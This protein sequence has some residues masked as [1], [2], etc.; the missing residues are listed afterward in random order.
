MDASEALGI[1]SADGP[2]S[3]PNFKL[4]SQPLVDLVAWL[5]SNSMLYGLLAEIG[6]TSV[7]PGGC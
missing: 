2:T 6:S 7:C 4:L 1:V 5:P 3:A